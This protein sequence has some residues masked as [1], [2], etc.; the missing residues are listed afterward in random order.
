MI[1]R[2]ITV[3]IYIYLVVLSRGGETDDY[4]IIGVE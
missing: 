1:V 2:V 3:Y 4:N